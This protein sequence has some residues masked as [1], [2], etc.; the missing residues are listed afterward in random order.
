[1]SSEA[2]GKPRPERTQGQS[3]PP[4]QQQEHRQHGN[5]AGISRAFVF[6]RKQA[7]PAVRGWIAHTKLALQE[8]QF[9]TWGQLHPNWSAD[10]DP[11]GA[12]L[13]FDVAAYQ[14]HLRA[15]RF[16]QALCYQPTISSTQTILRDATGNKPGGK[17][18]DNEALGRDLGEAE[19][20][21]P[22]GEGLAVLADVQLA[23]KG[24]GKNEWV[25]PKGCLS[26][27]YLSHYSNGATLPFV[28]YLVSL[29]VVKAIKNKPGL[30]SLPLHIKWPNDIYVNRRD[31]IGGILCNA[32]YDGKM[33]T[34]IIGVGINVNN[35]KPTTC[36]NDVI[37][38]HAADLGR[39]DA[40]PL[41]MTREELLA[42]FFFEFEQ[43]RNSFLVK[44]FAP[45]STEYTDN[46]LHTDQ[47][48][49]VERAAP[50]AAAPGGAN[51][52]P[53]SETETPAPRMEPARITGIAPSGNLT[54]QFANS[55]GRDE[56]VIPDTTSLDMLRGLVTRKR[57]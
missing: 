13:A 29:A 3:A 38:A 49:L 10:S 9:F 36:L 57:G 51:E 24:R 1:M 53:L 11:E 46:W 30:G 34:V 39:G 43:I 19:A 7:L 55:G 18:L 22:V 47:E 25:S 14:R 12:P 35:S 23:G 17:S 40:Q 21:T 54:V 15:Q 31:K 16:G 5:M 33:F 41:T 20:G 6:A 52:E 26:F 2:A 4:Q 45:F 8:P 44:G 28:Q 56:E 27:S 37:R 42:N 50:K 32:D 48:V